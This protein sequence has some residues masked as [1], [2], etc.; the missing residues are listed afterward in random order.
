MKKLISAACATLIFCTTMYAQISDTEA[1][2][3]VYGRSTTSLNGFWNALPD[4]S[5]SG[6]YRRVWEE[7]T[8]TSKTDFYE[9]S[10][11]GTPK[12]S[13]PGDFNSQLDHTKYTEGTVWYKHTF[14]HCPDS[15]P[16][17]TF[18]YFGAVNYMAE[19]YLNGEMI[20]KHEGGFTPFQFE[21]TDQLRAGDN[22]LIV[23]ADSRRRSNG[24][25]GDAFD[26]FGY[27]GITRDVMLVHTPGTF[28][29]DYFIRL[30]H[31]GNIRGDIH[32]DGPLSENTTVTV[33]IPELKLKKSIKAETDSM[34]FSS[35]KKPQRWAP[36]NPK[37]YDVEIICAGDTIR[38]RIGFRDVRTQGDKILLNG[39]PIFVKAVNIHE[40]TL[41]NP[42]RAFSREHAAQLL[43]YAK[44]LGCN[45][46]RLAHY[47]HSEHT[48]RLAEEMGMMVWDEIPVYQ[49]IQFTAPGVDEKIHRMMHEMVRRD[50]NRC[51]VTVWSLSNE[52]W[53]STPGRTQVLAPLT[54]ACRA[55]DDTRLIT[56]VINTQRYSENVMQLNDP[57]YDAC[58]LLCINEY[59]GWYIPWQGEPEQM[60]W[61]LPADKPLF[62]SEFGGEAKYGSDFGP[63]DSAGFWSE[64]FQADIYRKQIRMFDA[65]DNLTGVCPWILFDYLSLGRMHPIYQGGYNRKGLVD[66]YGE[67]KQAFSIMKEYY[68]RK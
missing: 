52:T 35:A 57:L 33:A 62:I 6:H 1:M 48:V 15:R 49:S 20:G 21:V 11:E 51:A 3:N 22:T 19:V 10:F 67:K 37:L 47:P 53:P 12:I 13:V 14:V 29:D 28:V 56:H 23:M 4:Y 9:Y 43:S 45:M 41:G 8:P 32:I 7:K 38:D 61:I 39:E 24:L 54:T 40:E 5:N 25:P 42:A 27:G 59:V 16:G 66:E 31:D 64:E 44:D 65:T 34:T 2:V 18:L 58:D 30:D 50:K 26:W 55:L 68:S 63:K 36:A 17:R 60:R 46:V